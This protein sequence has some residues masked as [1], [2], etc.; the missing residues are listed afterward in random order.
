MKKLLIFL[1][2]AASLILF[3]KTA[4]A[5]QF[6]IVGPRALGMGGASVASVN[7]ST[8]VYWNPAA[9]ADFRRVDIRIPASVGT[10]DHVGLEDKWDRLNNIDA[11]V[12]N[13][14]PAAINGRSACWNDRTSRNRR[15]LDG[16]VI[17]PYRSIG[18]SAIA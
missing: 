1:S 18:N 16:S 2:L 5:A 10:R 14:N 15:G 13:G 17:L 12:Q 11:L 6:G 4:P 8:A 3:T 7:D 9:L